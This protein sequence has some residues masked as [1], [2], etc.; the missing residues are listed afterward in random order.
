MA[1]KQSIINTVT[2]IFA[3]ATKQIIE[4]NT[5]TNITYSKTALKIYQVFLKPDIGC[6]V[7]GEGDFESLMIM[8]FS[9]EAALEIYT[10]YMTSMGMPESDITDN[11]ASNE[12]SDSIGELVNQI[13]GK[14]R[15]ELEKQFGISL[16]INQPKAIQ[17]SNTIMMSIAADINK[18]QN[19]RVSF[20]TEQKHPFYLELSIEHTEMISLTDDNGNGENEN[21]KELSIDELI[22]LNK[23]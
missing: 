16:K 5:L 11:Y 2:R 20:K 6:F 19:R 17:I 13:A 8:N 22:A 23:K 12:V 9:K 21:N 10:K 18:P 15:Q 14:A 4:A 1:R 3:D 7:V